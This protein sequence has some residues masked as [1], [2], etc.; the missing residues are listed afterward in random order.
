MRVVVLVLGIVAVS[1]ATYF[2]P[3]PLGTASERVVRIAGPWCQN[4]CLG[5]AEWD[6]LVSD[7]KLHGALIVAYHYAPQW[8]AVAQAAAQRGTHITTGPPSTEYGAV[9]YLHTNTIVV[10]PGILNLSVPA[11]A[12]SLAHEVAHAAAAEGALSRRPADC[13]EYEIVAF[14]WQ[15]HVWQQVPR[16]GAQSADLDELVRAWRAQQLRN[17]VVL[18]P[19]YQRLCLGRELRPL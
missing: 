2:L 14:A 16:H 7:G 17:Y 15:A 11:L 18:H 8:R 6:R 5:L 1:Y 13:L 10:T 4:G 3:L 19:T 12:A 9:Y